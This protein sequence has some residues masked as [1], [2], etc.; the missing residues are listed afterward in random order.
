MVTHAADHKFV[1]DHF[2]LAN[3]LTLLPYILLMDNSVMG[4]TI[5]SRNAYRVSRDLLA[6]DKEDLELVT[7]M[8]ARCNEFCCVLSSDSNPT[9]GLV[10]PQVTSLLA[11]TQTLLDTAIA[12]DL[13]CQF[14][15]PDFVSEFKNKFDTML[16]SETFLAC[17]AVTPSAAGSDVAR[18]R[19]GWAIVVDLARDRCDA[20]RERAG[21]G[22]PRAAQKVCFSAA[23]KAAESSTVAKDIPREEEIYFE[24]LDS[25]NNDRENQRH[26]LTDM[27]MWKKM[28]EKR[29]FIASVARDLLSIQPT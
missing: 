28:Y 26:V 25:V 12:R 10:I 21:A 22:A 1:F 18:F 5:A 4:D 13:N 11:T 29:P 19:R 16:V 15:F 7:E 6:A 3:I 24:L 23:A 20:V 9:A 8:M 2:S 27:K 17:F 14:I